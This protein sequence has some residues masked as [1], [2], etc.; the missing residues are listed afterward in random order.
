MQVESEK[1]KHK[2]KKNH[3]NNSM[4][5]KGRK[6][7]GAKDLKHHERIGKEISDLESR[8]AEETP[9]R[10]TFPSANQAAAFS[11]LAISSLTLQGLDQAK[12][13]TMTTIQNA[14]IPHALAGRDILGAAKTGS[15]KTLAFLIPVLEALFRAK[16]SPQ[17]GCGA[18]IL[19][20]TRELAVQI[21]GVLRKVGR[22]HTSLTAGL[23]VGG[24][25]EFYLEQTRI[26]NTHIIVAT[27]GRVLQ[28]LEQT[29][30]LDVSYLQVLVL[31]EA[32]RILDMGFRTQLDRILDYL[33]QQQRQTLLFSA[34]Q[35][36]KVSELATLSL[37]QP[38]Y[39]GVHDKEATTTP[40]RLVQ[41]YVV[42]PLQHKLDA[43]YSFVK[44]TTAKKAKHKKLIC[45]LASCAQV[46]HTW[47]LFC[48]LQPGIPV[49]A[50]HGRLAQEK[51]TQIYHQF[52]QKQ[53]AIL[54]CTDVASRGLDFPNV[55]WVI[56]MDA[57][58]NV[59]A[60]IH[61]SGRTARY[62][63]GG[64]AL[65]FLT[66]PEEVKFVQLLKERNIPINKS[67]I[68]PNKTLS[69]SQ[70]AASLVAA[71][72]KLHHLAKKAFQSY[73]RSIHLQTNSDIFSVQDLPLDDFA[74]SLGLAHTPKLKMK[75]QNRTQLR[76]KKNVNHKLQ[77]LKEQI[78]KE[79]EETKT[80]KRKRQVDEHDSERKHGPAETVDNVLDSNH[81]S[82]LQ[83]VQ[84][85][86]EET[87]RVDREQAQDRIRQKHR[88]DRWNDKDSEDAEDGPV[89]TL[90]MT[91]NANDSSS[92]GDDDSSSS[93]S[94]DASSSSDD[95]SSVVDV[96]AQEALVLQ[97]IQRSS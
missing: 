2:T 92:S 79:R 97:A 64:K 74:S 6:R 21:F 77:R 10:G 53:S 24:K 9:K 52:Q 66:P 17:D 51:R 54:F 28:H 13:S 88:Q 8:I 65:L 15:G 27:P 14:C 96:S 59:D 90:A 86:L 5:S 30:S 41:S 75:I 1:L 87:T 45:F 78:A 93:S 29:P 82:Y 47:E 69:V 39:L 58:E 81:T 95:D 26:G 18:L 48:A 32:D 36:R 61:R 12:F 11:S 83:R 55:D 37:K 23:L 72:P 63:A 22:Y 68:N 46:R 89:A 42:V 31:D 43:V 33:P 19:A 91:S 71:R 60:Y 40:K 85:R 35:T 44:S 76:E 50:L 4:A 67:S 56:Q 84:A 20:P 38:E 57:P 3:T 94:S 25:K 70:K 62:K 7:D 80:G 73:C 16:F 49:M 34:T